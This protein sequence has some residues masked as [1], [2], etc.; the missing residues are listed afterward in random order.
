MRLLG[1]LWCLLMLGR[2]LAAVVPVVDA[3]AGAV[4]LVSPTGSGD[5]DPHDA[6]VMAAVTA[7]TIGRT[8]RRAV[9][10]EDTAQ[11]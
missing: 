5:D 2:P 9:V 4:V 1:R 3:L 7:R 11:L 10:A 8:Q 6:R